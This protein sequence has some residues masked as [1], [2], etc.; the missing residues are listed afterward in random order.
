MSGARSAGEWAPGSQRRTPAYASPGPG[1]HAGDQHE[2]P[3]RRCTIEQLIYARLRP[4]A[5]QDDREWKRRMTALIE[6]N[7]RQATES[8]TQALL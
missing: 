5:A 4:P 1:E 6:S 3:A 8:G 2:L 7:P